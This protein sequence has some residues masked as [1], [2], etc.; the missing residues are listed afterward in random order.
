M[1]IPQRGPQLAALEADWCDEL[2][3]GGARGGGKSD[4]QLGYQEDGALRYGKGHRGIMF[5]KTYPE[6]EELQGRAMEVFPASG[7]F[8]KTQPSADYPFSN[9]WYWPSGAS[10]KM[11]YIERESDYGRYHGHQY[12]RI[13]FDEVTEYAT[14]AGLLKML[15]TLRSASGVPCSVRL[16][17]NPGGVGHIWV[18]DRYI[19]PAPPYTPFTDP[20]TQFTRLFIP[21]RMEDNPLLML[22]DPK[23][24]G[25]LL[26]ATAGNEALRQAWLEG[27]WDIIAGAFFE[28][29]ARRTHALRPFEIP[30]SWLRFRSFDWGSARPFSVGWWAVADGTTDHPRGALIRYREWYGAKSP[31]EGLKLDAEQVAD[32][33]KEREAGDTIAYGVADPS[34]WKVDGGPSIATRMV[35]RDVIWKPADN[36]RINGWDQMRQRFNG[37]D[38]KPMAYVFD[39]C[40]DWWRTVPLMQHDKNKPEDIDTDMEDHAADESRYGFMSRP[41]IPAGNKATPRKRRDYGLDPDPVENWKTA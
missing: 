32:G 22:N 25:R 17:G 29:L 39:T 1:W 40:A 19:D 10:T 20:D 37:E 11:R 8:Y 21:S 26:A 18:K 6:M 30:K 9:C 38:G 4:F 33:I 16:T 24:R 23:Y 14:P 36:S 2:F 13:S 12:T 41:W 35:N 27:N 5:R 34:I 15:S 3:F 7:A 31:N 28:G